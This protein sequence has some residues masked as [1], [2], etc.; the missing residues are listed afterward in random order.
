MTPTTALTPIALDY[1][2]EPPSYPDLSDWIP[3]RYCLFRFNPD[4][5]RGEV[6]NVGVLLES[7]Q[8]ITCAFVSERRPAWFDAKVFDPR[9]YRSL[10]ED[11][12]ERAEAGT[13]LDRF[14]QEYSGMYEFTEPY[15]LL[16]EDPAKQL[17]KLAARFL[18]EPDS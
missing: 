9:V 4:P 17:A 1:A 8:G 10:I 12:R 14:V 6:I 13:T 5:V 7:P 16:M 15:M 11:I 18:Q 2:A 3:G